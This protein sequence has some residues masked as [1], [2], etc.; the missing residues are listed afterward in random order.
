MRSLRR[1]AV[2]LAVAASIR[3][4]AC[5]SPTSPPSVTPTVKVENPLCTGGDC[6][7]LLLGMFIWAWHI[8]QSPFG[9]RIGTI[10]GPIGCIQ[11]PE[12]FSIRIGQQDSTEEPTN[13]YTLRW[14]PDNRDGI[15]LSIGIYL[16]V[17]EIARTK[18]FIPGDA[19]GWD[20]TFTPDP[21]S[22][23]SRYIAHLTPDSVPC[24][25]SSS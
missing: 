2:L 16:A 6:Q 18:S 11:F 14:T 9:W 24:K 4:W 3:S 10:E 5:S 22:D 23:G 8:P 25:P 12:K 1:L 15:D 21:L 17:P 7:T 13:V 20:L 19:P